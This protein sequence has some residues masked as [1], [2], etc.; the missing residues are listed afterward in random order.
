VLNL[1]FNQLGGTL[2]EMFLVPTTTT[3]TTPQSFSPPFLLLEELALE[4]NLFGGTIPEQLGDLTNLHLLRLGTNHLN[5]NGNSAFTT[6]T[7]TNRIPTTLG[8][9]VELQVLDL[10]SLGLGGSLPSELARLT[11]LEEFLVGN[12]ALTGTIPTAFRLGFKRLVRAD[13][14]S[15]QLVPAT[16]D[17]ISESVLDAMCNEL[18]QLEELIGDCQGAF[19]VAAN[20]SCCTCSEE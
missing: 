11:D 4:H 6:T 2:K 17:A 3:T 20:C 13:V 16:S 12:N 1:S 18:F 19:G 15:N 14:G 9:L 5:S 7:T 8:N 10:S